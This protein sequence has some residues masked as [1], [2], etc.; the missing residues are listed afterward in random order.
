M[1]LGSMGRFSY[2]QIGSVFRVV[3]RYLEAFTETVER[4]VSTY[5]G[6]RMRCSSLLLS[7]L[8]N[9]AFGKQLFLFKCSAVRDDSNSE[10]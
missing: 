2:L 8:E 6:D 5:V 3:L 7:G 4:F 9:G 1:S 10:H